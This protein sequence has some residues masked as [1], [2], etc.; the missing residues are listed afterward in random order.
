MQTEVN[1][2]KNMSQMSH[3]AA[4]MHEVGLSVF[5]LAFHIA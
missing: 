4:V 1:R 3:Y 5:H 2:N